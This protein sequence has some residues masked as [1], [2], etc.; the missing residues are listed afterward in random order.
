MG[1]MGCQKCHQM[2]CDCT[3]ITVGC[4]VKVI[5]TGT[6]WDGRVG[7]VQKYLEAATNTP[8]PDE[9]KVFFED[10]QMSGYFL[11]EE[12]EVIEGEKGQ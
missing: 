2:P 5:Y 6:E 8:D 11:R 10:H 4:T 12:L 9:Y 1:G 7:I 3:P